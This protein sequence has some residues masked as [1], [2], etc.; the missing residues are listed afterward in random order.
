M[1]PEGVLCE[2]IENTIYMSPGASFTHQ[3]IKQKILKGIDSF[4][5]KNKLGEVEFQENKSQRGL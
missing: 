4:V 2:V 5:S 3:K 1:L